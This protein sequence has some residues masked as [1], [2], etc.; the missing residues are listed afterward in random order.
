MSCDP[1]TNL[2]W[3]QWAS[4]PWRFQSNIQCRK[5]GE[6]EA[7]FIWIQFEIYTLFGGH[8]GTGGSGFFWTHSKMEVLTSWRILDVL[9]ILCRSTSVNTALIR[10][11]LITHH[12]SH[13]C[14]TFNRTLF[15][16]ILSVPKIDVE[17]IC[18]RTHQ[19]PV[20][21]LLHSNG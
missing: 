9:A 10:F 18:F 16:K 20:E 19:T 4:G 21:L 13:C 15:K 14:F 17:W 8:H 2:K 3:G 11:Q 5:Q 12:C 7:D 6:Q 1:I